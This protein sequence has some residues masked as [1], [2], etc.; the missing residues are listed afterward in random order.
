[1]KLLFVVKDI[2]TEHLGIMMLSS[3]LKQAGHQVDVAE[4]DLRK[5]YRKL[6]L[7]KYDIVAYS[8]T[9]PFFSF[10]L[11]INRKIK[12][13][14]NIFSIFGGPH[15]TLLPEII[16]HQSI[17]CICRGEGEYAL[18]D[19]VEAM[20]SRQ[21]FHDIENLW[22]K[23]ERVVHKNNLR[24][25][26]CNLDALPFPDRDLFYYNETVDRGK[27]HVLTTRGCLYDCSYCIHAF[28][29]KLYNGQEKMLRRR[30]VDNV[31]KEIRE[32]K[33]KADIRFIM[34]EDDLFT[35]SP[36]WLKE[37]SLQ[38]KKY[39]KLKFFCY[40][41][42]DMVT[43]SIIREL[44]EAGCASVSMGFESASE[45]LRNDILK[46]NMSKKTMINA[47]RLVK[48]NNI[49]LKTT[50]IIG[51]PTSSLE[52]D[53]DTLKINIQCKVDYAG[54]KLLMP[55]PKTE[56]REFSE[57]INVLT[58]KNYELTQKS[59]P[60][61]FKERKDK[62]AR[63]NLSK[64][65]AITVEFPFLLSFTRKIIYSPLGLIYAYVNLLWD[66]YCSFSRLYPTDFKGF[67]AGAR[68]HLRKFRD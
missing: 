21:D 49:R 5:I 35:S 58:D 28:Y 30:S 26:I 17:D 54:A 32:V 1:M 11:E 46:R 43:A 25:L 38:Y 51:I 19:L 68:K 42:P 47:A 57:K 27:M 12:K 67:W 33:E 9:S 7:G 37:F 55:Y 24:P 20:S 4:A 40:I 31:I 45:R 62:R 29:D 48:E 14:F 10:Y 36:E 52:D 53:I 44:K 39:I 64:L 22:V 3:L 50:N 63:E 60:F 16:N 59:S 61:S 8:C 13:D 41:R 23:T 66:G 65:F 15:P 6:R 2:D 18:L 34:F 56:A